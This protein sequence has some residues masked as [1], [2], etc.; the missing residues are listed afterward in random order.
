MCKSKSDKSKRGVLA[1]FLVSVF[2]V[3]AASKSF[4]QRVDR[5]LVVTKM[6]LQFATVVLVLVQTIAA[7]ENPEV[8]VVVVSQHQLRKDIRKEVTSVVQQATANITDTIGQVTSKVDWAVNDV[9][10]PLRDEITQ[11]INSAL[12]NAITNV[13]DAVEQFLKPLLDELGL[14]KLPGKTSTNPAASCEEVKAN[15]PTAPSGYYWIQNSDIPLVQVYCKMS[16]IEVSS[17]NYPASSCKEIKELNSS[18]TSGY[19]SIKT[20]NES[21]IRVYCDMT[22]TCGGIT[23]G[24]MQ[25]ANLNMTNSS[26]TCPQGLGA[27]T[28]S[29]RRVCN[30]Y[31]SVGCS[32][33]TFEVRGSEYSHVC[34]KMVGYRS[35]APDGFGGRS[36]ITID[37]DYVEGASLTHGNSPRKHI[38]TFASGSGS[39]ECPC[40]STGTVTVPSFVGND[41]F[42]D[43]LNPPLWDGEG[44]GPSSTCCSFNSPPWFSK[45]LLSPTTDN[46]EMRLCGGT[47]EHI[48]IEAVEL[49][50]Q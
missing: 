50:V 1:P 24:W 38:W 9:I 30:R 42:C 12:E 5:V 16:E 8:P 11:E 36:S 17:P 13:T 15:S 2:S 34:G 23:G 44:C 26:H 37:G 25:V 20:A 46:M 7:H 6:L 39:N 28:Y 40:L 43:Y 45:R 18:S 10:E 22:R 48:F 21:I 4:I 31:V 33:A 14:Q 32:S 27:T 29:S 19:Y 35:G 49:Y 3:S 47:G 41:Y